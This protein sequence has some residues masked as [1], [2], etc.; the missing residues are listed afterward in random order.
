MATLAI[1]RSAGRE[2]KRITEEMEK[3]EEGRGRK[4]RNEER[5]N[6]RIAEYFERQDEEQEKKDTA[7]RDC[8][9]DSKERGNET[10]EEGT[11]EETDEL[12]HG[13]SGRGKLATEPQGGTE[14]KSTQQSKTVS[15]SSTNQDAGRAENQDRGRTITKRRPE[16][17]GEEGEPA[18][19]R[20]K[21]DRIEGED[22]MMYKDI[23]MIE[24]GG[25]LKRV[26]THLIKKLRRLSIEVADKYCPARVGVE[27]AK[28][29]LAAGEVIDLLTGWDFRK[30]G[31]RKAARKYV[32]TEAPTRHR[33]SNVCSG[34][35]N[36]ELGE[37]WTR[38]PTKIDRSTNAS[39]VCHR[40]LQDAGDRRPI[41][42]T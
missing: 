2:Y 16:E 30:E 38:Q 21:D 39:Q 22:E 29:G 33:I 6:R 31:H 34:Q 7:A 26:D 5:E 41:L 12:K 25:Q 36:A 15:S 14:S 19:K 8:P 17:A 10:C 28:M 35:R 32:E 3:D 9:E 24:V 37:K 23:E 18:M 13:V 40:D 27:A 1:L 42:P 4:K 11:E 20:S